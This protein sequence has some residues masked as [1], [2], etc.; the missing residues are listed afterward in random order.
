MIESLIER[1]C[2]PLLRRLGYELR[3][4]RTRE[5]GFHADY[6][7]QLCT[8]STVI[9]VGVGEGTNALYRAW[10]DAQLVLVEPLPQ[11]RAAMARIAARHRC[12]LVHKAVGAEPGTLTLNVDPLNPQMSSFHARTE[13]TRTGNPIEPLSVDV[14]TLDAI[15]GDGPPLS[16]P[17]L[18][19]ID[20]EGHE[21]EVLRGA[22]ELLPRVDW[23]IAEVSIAPRFAGGYAFEDLLGFL[24][25]Q[26]FGLF[27]ILSSFQGGELGQRFADCLFKRSDLAD[28]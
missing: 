26:G 22:T 15:A 1:L 8:P 24:R 4:R 14:T 17:I 10:P 12:R 28:P 3:R 19:K 21:L 27:A 9:D 13:L 16:A 5:I 20:T 25:G 18:L 11:F 7:R 6:L 23:V 2:A